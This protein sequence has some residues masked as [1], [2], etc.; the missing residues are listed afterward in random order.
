[1]FLVAGRAP[2]GARLC[3]PRTPWLLWLSV[4]VIAV[5]VIVALVNDLVLPYEANELLTPENEDASWGHWLGTDRLGRDVFTRLAAASRPALQY[6]G[7]L[8]CFG[9]IAG[10]ALGIACRRYTPRLA[11]GIAVCLGW[12]AYVP[13]LVLSL[14]L[15]GSVS[16][17]SDREVTMA[18][19]MFLAVVGLSWGSARDHLQSRSRVA[20]AAAGASCLVAAHVLMLQ[21]TLA[22]F[23]LHGSSFGEFSWGNDV[24]RARESIPLN[25]RTFLAN[26]AVLMILVLAFL[27]LGL[28]LTAHGEAI[29]RDAETSAQSSPERDRKTESEFSPEPA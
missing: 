11:V 21:A 4:A 5:Y 7:V 8:V 15:I 2:N 20:Y 19:T 1:M 23:E 16:L 13:L 17:T 6:A 18:L 9:W 12:A 29:S 3:V 28:Q 27:T 25:W 10:A 26:A 24:G 14:L 22:Y